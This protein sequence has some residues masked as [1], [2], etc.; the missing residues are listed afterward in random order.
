M[1]KTN[2]KRVITCKLVK[3]PGFTKNINNNNTLAQ[4]CAECCYKEII[5]ENVS[6]DYETSKNIKTF[7]FDEYMYSIPEFDNHYIS[8]IDDK[9]LIIYKR[10]KSNCC[11]AKKGDI[12]V[13]VAHTDKKHRNKGLMTELLKNLS[14]K[15]KNIVINTYT[16]P[17]VRISKRL[18]IKS[19]KG[20]F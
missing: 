8:Y 19:F 14:L 11:F 16:D 13:C 20:N 1:K 4:I 18:H 15:Y 7:L 5:L 6:I 12:L 3:H 9:S 10:Q 17:L 2:L